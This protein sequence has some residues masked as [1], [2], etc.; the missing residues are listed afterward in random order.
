MKSKNV[1]LI[2]FSGRPFNEEAAK[3][4]I[5][6]AMITVEGENPDTDSFVLVSGLTDVGI[7]RLGYRLAEKRNWKTVGIACSKAEDYDC[8][9]VDVK[10]IVGDEWGDESKTFISSI[11]V[12]IRVGGGD[13]SK[14][15]IQMA[16]DRDITAFEYDLPEAAK[17]EVEA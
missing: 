8:F 10:Q 14:K 5:E 11:D 6:A 16:K 13:Q 3:L 2:G 17:V 9:D 4:L 12:I 7:P 15:E 1:G